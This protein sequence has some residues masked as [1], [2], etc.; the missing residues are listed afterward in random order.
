[1]FMEHPI[2][3]AL[4]L[5]GLL[6]TAYLVHKFIDTDNTSVTAPVSTNITINNITKSIEDL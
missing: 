3:S 5:G 6:G 2:K 1:M 4:G